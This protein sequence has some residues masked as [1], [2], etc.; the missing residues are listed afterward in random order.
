MHEFYLN[1]LDL[2]IHI[3]P[4]IRRRFYE[5]D[6]HFTTKFDSQ[7]FIRSD[8]PGK[9]RLDIAGVARQQA[10]LGTTSHQR[11]HGVGA[12]ETCPSGD[13]HSHHQSLEEPDLDPVQSWC[14]MPRSL[15]AWA[16]E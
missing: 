13:G 4:C 16:A 9:V 1:P 3:G 7:F 5:V 6:D 11:L 2:F 8:K 15:S 14:I 12:D 10:N